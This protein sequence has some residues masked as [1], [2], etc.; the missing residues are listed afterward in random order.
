MKERGKLTRRE[1]MQFSAL[2]TAGLVMTA[3]GGTEAPATTAPAT[4]APTKEA[5]PEAT[6]VPAA[7]YSEAPALAAMVKAGTLPPVDERLPL[8]PVVHTP[9]EEVGQ[10]GG[11]WH[12]AAVAPAMCK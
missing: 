8:D 1:F 11:T 12:R 9:V 6:A 3:C 4:T 5:A 10:Y 7:K 2:A